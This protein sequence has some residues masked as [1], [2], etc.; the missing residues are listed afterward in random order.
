MSKLILILHRFMWSMR[1][2][3]LLRLTHLLLTRYLKEE[4]QKLTDRGIRSALFVI[5]EFT[6]DFES[7]WEQVA[8]SPLT[9]QCGDFGDSAHCR[10]L[11]LADR[12]TDGVARQFSQRKVFVFA[13]TLL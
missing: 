3:K 10:Y 11:F 1:R 13:Y 2:R 7:Y 8:D 4:S 12:N 6:D 5:G 9:I